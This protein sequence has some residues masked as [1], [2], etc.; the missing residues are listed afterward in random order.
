MSDEK[1]LPA[2]C[3]VGRLLANSAEVRHGQGTSNV[4]WVAKL[5]SQTYGNPGRQR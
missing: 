1:D 5:G 4:K 2:A 3:N